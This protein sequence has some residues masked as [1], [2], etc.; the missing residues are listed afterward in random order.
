VQSYE[1]FVDDERY[2]VPAFLIVTVASEERAR[3]QAE[4]HLR[5]S[6]YHRSVEVCQHGR[7]LFRIGQSV[8]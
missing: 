1:I 6:P 8:R 2:S 3:T 4:L 5:S 7:L